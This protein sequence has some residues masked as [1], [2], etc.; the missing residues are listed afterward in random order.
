[1]DSIHTCELCGL[2]SVSWHTNVTKSVSVSPLTL[3]EYFASIWPDWPDP[4]PEWWPLVMWLECCCGCC[5]W[6]C[7]C[8]KI[9]S[10][11][12]SGWPI[13]FFE[14]AKIVYEPLQL[15]GFTW[16]LCGLLLHLCFAFILGCM[17][18]RRL[19]YW[20]VLVEYSCTWTKRLRTCLYKD[21]LVV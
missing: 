21:C 18:F 8:L 5:C 7:A 12:V 19:G 4:E 11:W 10:K 16:N 2:L 6:W 15:Y 9:Q 20:T 3:S 17:I 13:L 14:C 1:M